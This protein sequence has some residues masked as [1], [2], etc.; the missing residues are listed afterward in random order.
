MGSGE[1]LFTLI[2][3]F[4]NPIRYKNKMSKIKKDIDKVMATLSTNVLLNTFLDPGTAIAGKA[5]ELL[6]P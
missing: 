6:T 1:I 2:K 3:P 5:I 4:I